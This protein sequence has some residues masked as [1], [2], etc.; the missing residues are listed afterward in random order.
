MTFYE[1]FMTIW[2]DWWTD[3]NWCEL[4]ND[5]NWWEHMRS[6]EKWG[7]ENNC[8]MEK[9]SPTLRRMGQILSSSD[10]R[11]LGLLDL[12]ANHVPTIS[13]LHRGVGWG[14]VALSTNEGCRYGNGTRVQCHV[15]AATCHHSG[16]ILCLLADHSGW[17]CGWHAHPCC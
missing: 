5:E 4:L 15:A 12:L 8:W 6:V 7:S 10:S 14:V 1:H 13:T 2:S 9:A 16:W 17:P 11:V 3:T